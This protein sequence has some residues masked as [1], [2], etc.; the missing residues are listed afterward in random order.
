LLFDFDSIKTMQ[1]STDPAWTGIIQSS[2]TYLVP[3]IQSLYTPGARVA[4][5][6]TIR[7]LAQTVDVSVAM[8]LPVG[9]TFIEASPTATLTNGNPGFAF[10]LPAAQSKDISVSFTAPA[11]SGSPELK[12]TVNTTRNGVS[13]KYGDYSIPFT[14]SGSDTGGSKAIADLQALSIPSSSDR[15]ARDQ[16]VK[17]LQ[18]ATSLYSSGKYLAAVDE[19]TEVI[20]ALLKIKS[21]DISATGC[22]RIVCCRKQK[23]NGR[24][25]ENQGRRY[26]W[27]CFVAQMGRVI[28]S[29]VLVI[30]IAC[31]LARAGGA[32]AARCAAA[33][34]TRQERAVRRDPESDEG[35]GA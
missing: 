16:A 14:V 35:N 19:F 5:T 9:A 29:I 27:L 7:N 11:T 28:A 17:N 12:T 20:Q 2:L 8:T 25:N 4:V 10:N 31:D 6:T 24:R 13:K 1:S 23:S 3:G 26:V 18:S 34:E 15:N 30:H 21:V 32:A 22:K 33:A